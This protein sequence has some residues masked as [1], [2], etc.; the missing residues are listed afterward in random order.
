[1]NFEPIYLLKLAS[2]FLFSRRR[3]IFCVVFCF[4]I[5]SVVPITSSLWVLYLKVLELRKKMLQWLDLLLPKGHLREALRNWQL[6]ERRLLHVMED[7]DGIELS[8][9]LFCGSS[10]SKSKVKE[11]N[12]DVKTEEGGVSKLMG[13]SLNVADVSFKHFLPHHVGKQD[14][15]GL[16]RNEQGMQPRENFW[17][18]LGKCSSQEAETA[19]NDVN[20]KPLQFNRYQDLWSVNNKSNE[21]S[22][23]KLDQQE[24]SANLWLE[25]GSKRKMSFEEMNHQKK[26]E[27]EVE[28]ADGHGKNHIG[29]GIV[30]SSHV[31]E[32]G[33]FAE[34][35]DVA[36]SE[37]EVSTSRLA[38]H[39][40]SAKQHK[41]SGTDVSKFKDRQ[42]F[43]EAHVNVVGSQAGLELGNLA[44]SI[45]FSLQQSTAS[46]PYSL[47][48]KIPTAT[49]TTNSSG[50]TLPYV[51]QLM[52]TTQSE[53]PL[54][55]STSPNTFPLAF[56]Y[57]VVQLPTL[58]TD[59]N[60]ASRTQQLAGFDVRS[61]RDGV[62]NANHSHDDLKL[63]QG[64]LPTLHR[65]T[66]ESGAS[67][68]SQKEDDSK[69]NNIIF[70]PKEIPDR[71]TIVEGIPHEVSAIRPGIGPDVKFGGCG[72]YPDLPWVQATGPGPNGKTISG[73][74]YRYGQNQ[75]RIVCACHGSH[76]SSEE[77]VQH[78]SDA[79]SQ[80]NNA[81]LASF[82]GGNPTASAA[83]S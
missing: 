44:Y 7:D 11:N 67:S 35:E 33:S 62:S 6:Q 28:H 48:V 26:H 39:D 71:R 79:P 61:L 65:A 57:P 25:P 75:T 76:M 3:I 37:V 5:A 31:S 70:K 34:N 1:M 46:A 58:D 14:S 60:S 10:A 22:E 63:N 4:G 42:S 8:L 17:T 12:S 15:S 20:E 72:S 77:F 68:S 29:A 78:A 13:G 21:V 82:A 53:R 41:G 45:P 66:E 38:Q 51:M 30:K 9:G 18:D 69:G 59:S 47:P 43:N 81:G 64:A 36:E 83:Q 73:V 50:S 54:V 23:E 16:Q 32:D 52:S 80:E 55:Q 2:H 27:K 19:S 24:I 74:A 40:D 49:T 56:G